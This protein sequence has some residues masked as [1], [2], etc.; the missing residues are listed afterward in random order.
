MNLLMTGQTMRY[1]V[2]Y[3][4]ACYRPP[5]QLIASTEQQFGEGDK[6]TGIYFHVR[7]IV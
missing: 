7:F 3:C 5:Y 6:V 2:L 4:K 1:L